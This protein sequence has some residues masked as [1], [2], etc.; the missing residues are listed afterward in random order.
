MKVAL[1]NYYPVAIQSIPVKN[2]WNQNGFTDR[3]GDHLNWT[4]LRKYLIVD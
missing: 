3:K 4:S 1:T 2:V